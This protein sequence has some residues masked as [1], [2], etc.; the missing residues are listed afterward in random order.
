MIRKRLTKPVWKN[1]IGA[2]L[3]SKRLK[4]TCDNEGLFS[5]PV[6]FC[7]QEKYRS[8]R[9]CRKHVFNKKKRLKRFSRLLIL[10]KIL[11]SFTKELK[12]PLCLH[13]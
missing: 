2:S 6:P 12:H 1:A 13:F 8:K 3:K 7:E 5:C 4:L 11:M 9:G 10:E